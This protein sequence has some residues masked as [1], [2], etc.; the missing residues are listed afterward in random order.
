MKVI[1]GIMA[2]FA[3]L[4]GVDRIFNNKFGLGEQFERGILMMGYVMLYVTGMIVVSPLIADFLS[5]VFRLVA[6]HTPM[7]PSIVPCM[8]FGGSMGGA[9][10]ALEIAENTDLAY[11]NGLIVASM[12]GITFSYI[13]PVMMG[14]VDKVY[15]KDVLIGLLCGIITIPVGCT[16]AGL[17]RGFTVVELFW[18]LL[19]LVILAVVIV[20][21]LIKV[22][23]LCLK[24]FTLFGACVKILVTIGLV[25]GILKYLTGIEIIEGLKPF[26]EGGNLSVRTGAIMAGAF[27]LVLVLSRILSKPLKAIGIKLHINEVAASSLM[28]SLT[29]SLTTIGNMKVMD[30]KGRVLNAAFAVSGAYTLSTHLSFALAMNGEYAVAMIVGK[31]VSGV[32]AVIVAHFIYEKTGISQ[33]A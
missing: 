28:A 27:P 31:L 3:V 12:M 16:V 21:G 1:Y 33:N 24:I 20:I 5:P 8:F 26:E 15:H 19:P 11:F 32:C 18:D 10:L 14:M 9:S 22:S 23:D 6:D 7:D 13:I 2:L 25:L 17:M 30:R 29:T 4:G